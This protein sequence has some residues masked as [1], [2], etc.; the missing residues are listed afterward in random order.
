MS[1]TTAENRF[2]NI[3]DLIGD[4][5]VEF[6]LVDNEP[7]VQTINP[8]FVDIFG[9]DEE[10]IVGE[11]LNSYIV[12]ETNADEAAKFDQQTKSGECN[13][14]EVTRVTASGSRD[15]L[16]RGV[17]YEKEGESYGFA[18]YTDITEKNQRKAELEETKKDLE[19]S[20]EKLERFA[21]IASHDLQ[22]PLRMISSYIEL[23][24]IEIGEDLDGE[25]VEYMEF[26]EN[27]ANRM[28]DMI[29]GLL[30]YS[31]VQ[32]Q[33]DPFEEVEP[34][35]VL[36]EV[37]QDLELKIAGTDAKVQVRDVPPVTADRN[38]LSQVFQNLLKNA[39]EHGESNILI[40]ITATKRDGYTEFSVADNGPGIPEH[41]M[42]DLF[43]IFNKGTE[44]D[45]TGIGLAVCKEI[46]DRHGGDISVD[47][48]VGEGT[49]FTFTIPE[50][51]G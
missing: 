24:E 21:Y 1:L 18:I 30:A 6:K 36:E 40:E 45:G 16:Y 39:I 14:A 28:R 46:I 32:T 31:R 29:D 20:N 9:Y 38:Q 48:T 22:E 12:P 4:A 26:V 33:A 51:P 43:G 23:L 2:R 11:S 27:G 42:D 35:L 5:A 25:A 50:V 41:L 37:I 47:S 13:A 8:A 7:I 10:E 17:P 49:T 15:F 44:S 19:D 34:K 3:F